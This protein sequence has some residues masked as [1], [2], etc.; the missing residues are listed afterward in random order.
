MSIGVFF[1]RFCAI[2]DVKCVRLQ[3]LVTPS[4]LNL[5]RIGTTD[6]S[7]ITDVCS[8]FRLCRWARLPSWQAVGVSARFERL[9]MCKCEREERV[10]HTMPP[11]TVE[12]P[13]EDVICLRRSAALEIAQHRGTPRAARIGQSRS[14]E[15]EP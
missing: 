10:V 15:I 9:E 8:G 7:S 2:F 14:G 11:R 1:L 4:H 12:H 6:P 13:T 3:F 5:P